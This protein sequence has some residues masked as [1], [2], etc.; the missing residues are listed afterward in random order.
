MAKT[1]ARKVMVTFLVTLHEEVR[2][3]SLKLLKER[4]SREAEYLSAA[5]GGNADKPVKVSVA[6][7]E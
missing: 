1:K 6:E 5:I 4:A 3:H 2:G 7:A